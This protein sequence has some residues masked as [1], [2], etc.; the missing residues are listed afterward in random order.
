MCRITTESNAMTNY[1]TWMQLNQPSKGDVLQ[2][3]GNPVADTLSPLTTVA[4]A[5]APVGAA[6]A[7]CWADV[8]VKVEADTLARGANSVNLGDGKFITIPANTMIEVPNVIA[9][10]TAITMTDV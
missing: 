7:V 9:G 3:Q 8:A 6:Y 10:V 5:V 2:M 1:V 4:T